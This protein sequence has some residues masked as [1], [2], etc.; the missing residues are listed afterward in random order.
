[1]RCDCDGI[2]EIVIAKY[3]QEN[4]IKV[5]KEAKEEAKERKQTEERM[6]AKEGVMERKVKVKKINGA[7]S[8]K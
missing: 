8:K 1:M 7:S 3:S 4:L 2:I 5:A 6:E